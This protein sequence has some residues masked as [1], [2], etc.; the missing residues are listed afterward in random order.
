MVGTYI[1]DDDM[2]EAL[3]QIVFVIENDVTRMYELSHIL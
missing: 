2:R 3:Y 1:D